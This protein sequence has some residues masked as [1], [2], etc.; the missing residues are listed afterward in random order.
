MN[1]I[2]KENL[3]AN[4]DIENAY[5]TTI[6]VNGQLIDISIDPDDIEIEK[7]IDLANKIIE[8]SNFTNQRHEK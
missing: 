2:N 6:T 3:K 1:I 7:T 5:Q 8:N 4:P